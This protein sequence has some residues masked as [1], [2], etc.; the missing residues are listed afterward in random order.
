MMARHKPAIGD[1]REPLSPSP[2]DVGFAVTVGIVVKPFASNAF[3][4]AVSDMRV[5]LGTVIPGVDIGLLK[6]QQLS[7]RWR[8]LFAADEIGF[9][10]LIQE[11][12][13]LALK[14]IPEPLTYAQIRDTVLT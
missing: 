3:I 1:W 9:V 10:S 7:A 13:A 5:S 14:D 12:T 4:V 8:F 6:E 2:K 11:Q